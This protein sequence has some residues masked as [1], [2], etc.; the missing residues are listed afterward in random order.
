MGR[1]KMVVD[2]LEWSLREHKQHCL[3]SCQPRDRWTLLLEEALDH[4][5]DLQ[6]KL[7]KIHRE[8]ANE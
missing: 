3:N 8:S 4:I 6:S 7:D 1:K 2:K 5:H